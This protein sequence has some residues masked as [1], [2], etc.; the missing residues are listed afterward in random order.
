MSNAPKAFKL[1]KHSFTKLVT[2]QAKA[3]IHFQELH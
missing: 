2:V 3:K 1:E